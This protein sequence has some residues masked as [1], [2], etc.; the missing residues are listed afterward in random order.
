MRDLHSRL[1]RFEAEPYLSETI[2][3]GQWELT[4]RLDPPRATSGQG[5]VWSPVRSGTVSAEAPLKRALAKK[6][7]DW[8]R[9]HLKE[10]CFL[11]AVNICNPD[12]GWNLDEIRAIY[13]PDAPIHGG[14]GARKS[15]F[16]PYLSRVAGVLIVD[17]ATLGSERT[18]R[19]RHHQN[20]QTRL[21]DCLRFLL[22][23][24]PLGD[25]IGS[26]AEGV[27]SPAESYER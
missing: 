2:R 26:T 3:E 18:A 1:G 14:T 17:N 20:P 22:V 11:V 6:A 13:T 24:Q 16:A 10:P 19:V 27:S 15:L 7:Q 4:G 25:L 9:T 21:P 12:F 5:Q 8:R 23:E